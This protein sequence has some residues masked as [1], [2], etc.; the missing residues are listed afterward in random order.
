[1][2]INMTTFAGRSTHYIDV[3]LQSLAES[4][5]RD[6]PLNLILGSKDT[7]HIEHYRGVANIVPW[8][9]YAQWRSRGGRKRRS[10]S[11]NAIRALE[12]GDDDYCLC[13]E[14]DILF[15]KHWFS[16]LML[17]VA[18]IGRKDYVLNLGQRGA[19][20]PDRRYA[21]HTGA[22]LC[23]A[24]GIFYPSKA[25]RDAVAWYVERN[26]AR[27]MNDTLVGQYAKEQA[28]LYNTVPALVEHIGQV[29]CF[30]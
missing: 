4:D 17:T 21:T 15:H 11:V 26:L 12:Y 27:G 19:R 29:S 2:I 20:S 28:A 9:E 25:L 16:E 30:H 10:C 8:D 13:C 1:M 6:I 3:T 24:Q 23:G 5:G 22:Y 14:D 7:S 18:E